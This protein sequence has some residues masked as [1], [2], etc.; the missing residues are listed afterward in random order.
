MQYFDDNIFS[1]GIDSELK[2]I[3]SDTNNLRLITKYFSDK[4][5][6]LD[7]LIGLDDPIFKQLNE[8]ELENIKYKIFIGTLEEY[9]MK[10]NT[11]AD[12]IDFKLNKIK[13]AFVY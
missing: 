9:F 6:N 12:A 2:N 4:S 13:R 8:L 3:Y 7:D 5:N 11:L 1:F 10:V